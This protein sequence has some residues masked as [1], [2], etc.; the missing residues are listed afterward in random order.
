MAEVPL[1]GTLLVGLEVTADFCALAILRLDSAPAP[2]PVVAL[3]AVLAGLIGTAFTA[4][5]SS[6]SA[7]VGLESLPYNTYEWPQYTHPYA[8]NGCMDILFSVLLSC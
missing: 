7:R 5:S 2:P 6:F 3:L 1:D 8:A 4:S